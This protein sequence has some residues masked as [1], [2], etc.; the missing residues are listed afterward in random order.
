[1]KRAGYTL[2]EM[3]VVIAPV[4]IIVTI[5][6]TVFAV[7]LGYSHLEPAINRSDYLVE[8]KGIADTLGVPERD[9]YGDNTYDENDAGELCKV[10]GVPIGTSLDDLSSR[11]LKKLV[12]S[13]R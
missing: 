11:R 6:V 3:F 5:A 8:S 4:A 1:M 7:V 2:I 9:G 10:L 12:K 13:R